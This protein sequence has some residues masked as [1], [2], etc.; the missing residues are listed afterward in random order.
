MKN[1]QCL[2]IIQVV[3]ELDFE[4]QSEYTLI[5]RA[6]DSVTAVFAEVPVVIQ[7]QDVNDCA[8]EFSKD[9]YNVSVLE[10]LQPFKLSFLQIKTT[11]NDT[12]MPHTIIIIAYFVLSRCY[13]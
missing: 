5:I 12:G 11:D 2:G 8:P 10:A 6:T 7:I 4:T 3:D 13:I 9:M 1:N